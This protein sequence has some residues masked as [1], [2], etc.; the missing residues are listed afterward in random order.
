MSHGAD[1]LH[2]T[3][4]TSQRAP[5]NPSRPPTKKG[6]PTVSSR[7]KVVPEPEPTRRILEGYG[8]DLAAV[9]LV[10]LAIVGGFGVYAR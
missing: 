7:S 10:A 8:A 3:V 6:S 2:L 4:A 5:S 1:S 9:V